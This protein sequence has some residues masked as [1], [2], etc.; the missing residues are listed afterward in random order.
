M[1]NLK[2]NKIKKER[3]EKNNNPSWMKRV[4]SCN[5]SKCGGACC[6][7]TVSVL[8]NNEEYQNLIHSDKGGVMHSVKKIKD[9]ELI[10]TNAVCPY[11]TMDCKC[12]M[13]G[14]KKQPYTCDVFPMHHTDGVYQAVKKLCG[15]RF[16]KVKNPKYKYKRK[17]KVV[18]EKTE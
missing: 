15:Y 8:R 11:M 13:H 1:K 10:V 6:R 2:L 7:Y 5:P 14:K 4:G 9:K 3:A 12:S 16:V 18:E 17:K